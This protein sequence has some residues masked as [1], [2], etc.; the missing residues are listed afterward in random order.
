MIRGD[1]RLTQN[2]P[3]MITR[4]KIFHLN[5]FSLNI[6]YN[7]TQKILITSSNAENILKLWDLDHGEFLLDLN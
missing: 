2:C 1:C 3:L 7:R 6:L 5:T 4:G